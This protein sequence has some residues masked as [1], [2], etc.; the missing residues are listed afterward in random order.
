MR[1]LE[2]SPSPGFD[3]LVSRLV[4]ME[5]SGTLNFRTV[6]RNYPAVIITAPDSGAW[7]IE[8]GHSRHQL[9][10]GNVYF[11]GLGFTPSKMSF[12]G[13]LKIWVAILKPQAAQIIF[14]D[15]AGAFVNEISCVSDIHAPLRLLSEQLWENRENRNNPEN[16]VQLIERYFVRFLERQ[17][18]KPA[19]LRALDKIHTT[20]G[21]V[22]VRELADAAFTCNRHLLRQF[23]GQV[24]VNPK[25][26]SAMVRFSKLM[27]EW[28]LNPAS[29]V[30]NLAFDYGFYDLSHLNKEAVRFLGV[31][32]HEIKEQN[33]SLNQ[34][35]V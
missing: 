21:K 30:G 32:L 6:P 35:L 19:I 7:Q 11:A 24:G 34:N 16:S 14:G 27:N 20:K 28:I 12:N 23:I 33:N 9:H 2:F 8:I 13:K 25:K 22:S 18:I 31:P 3:L 15:N 26:Y 10:N 29:D 17:N 5:N 4:F 1:Y